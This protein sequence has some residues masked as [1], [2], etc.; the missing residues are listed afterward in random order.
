VTVARKTLSEIAEHVGGRIIGNAQVEI[1]KVSSIEDAGPGDI[2]FLAHPHY[3]S[4]L[5]DC[6]AAAVIVGRGVVDGLPPG[7]P[8]L[9]EV[10]NPYLAFARILQLFTPPPEFDGQISSLASIDPTATLEDEVTVFP[11][12]FIGA[13]VT[14][15]RKTVLYP[16]VY[17][18]DGAE[19]GRDCVLYPNVTVRE[20]CRLG[21]RVILHPGVVIGSDGFGYAGEGEG[22]IK[23]PQV[24]I[25]VIE[26]NVEIGANSTVDRATL[27]RTVIRRGVKID[28]LVQIAHNVSVGENS[29]IAAQTGIAGSTRIGKDV[30]LAGQVGVVNHIEIGDGARIGPQSGVP[31]S[32]PPGALRSSGIEASP[33]KEWLRVMALLP[34]L[35]RLWSSVRTLEKKISHLLKAGGKEPKR[36]ARR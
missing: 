17:L 32:V 8:A 33:H 20:G 23:I 31:R 4:F 5:A 3:K 9:V 25:A 34:Q 10:S 36:H 12:V 28:N 14:V 27:G 7:M 18:G 26:D 19:V 15:K 1:S 6:R 22:R 29:I 35:P 24:G 13:R 16:G 21:D 11:H 2:T 30:I